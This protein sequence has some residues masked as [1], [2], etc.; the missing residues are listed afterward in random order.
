MYKTKTKQS[1]ATISYH[2]CGNN[3]QQ[4]FGRKHGGAR[5]CGIGVAVVCVDTRR[6]AFVDIRARNTIAGVP[7]NTRA[8]KTSA[9]E[10]LSDRIESDGCQIG[11]RGQGVVAIVRSDCAL[12]DVDARVN[13][14][15]AV[16]RRARAREAANRVLAQRATEAVVVITGTLVDVGARRHRVTGEAGV[17][18]AR[19]RA[20]R[21]GACSIAV[22]VVGTSGALVDV[23]A[24]SACP[25]VPASA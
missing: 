13:T 12:V 15:P 22:A 19:E 20:C 6:W 7:T 25:L 2:A 18:R 16:R 4:L 1:R 5:T 17:A 24:R 23:K 9:D 14:V 8:L 21:V 11:A 10:C 3:K